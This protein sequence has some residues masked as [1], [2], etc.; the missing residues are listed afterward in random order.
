MSSPKVTLEHPSNPEL[1]GVVT[2][3][4]PQVFDEIR[5]Q[6][7][8]V[9]LTNLGRAVN[10]PPLKPA[11]LDIEAYQT[12]MI[13]ATLE[14]VIDT[15]PRGFFLEEKGRPVLNLGAM[16][17]EEVL[18][19]DGVLWILYSAYLEWRSSFRSRRQ[20]NLRNTQDGRTGTGDRSGS[21]EGQQG[22]PEGTGGQHSGDH[23]AHGHADS[24]VDAAT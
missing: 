17:P 16:D 20:G 19:Q 22:H 11:D 23:P 14:H 15:A 2:F 6:R 12:V 21:P 4:Y 13:I 9:E 3:R 8:A 5:I 10:A 1:S 24:G 18:E 7:R